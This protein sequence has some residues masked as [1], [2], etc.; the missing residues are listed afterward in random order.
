MPLYYK[1]SARRL[2]SMSGARISILVILLIT[3]A[4][5]FGACASSEPK[6]LPGY[7]VD[8][9]KY[10]H[11]N[12]DPEKF[13]G[14]SG[15]SKQGAA[16]AEEAARARLVRMLNSSISVETKRFMRTV[17]KNQDVS[18]E[19]GFIQKV[20]SRSEFRHDNLIQPVNI[21]VENNGT[22]W[23]FVCM[24]KER[25]AEALREDFIE[26]FSLFKTANTRA[27][28]TMNEQDNAA[29]TVA[30][31]QAAGYVP[32]LLTGIGALTSIGVEVREEEAQFR[33]AWV[34]L[35]AD[36]AS[37]RAAQIQLHWQSD[38]F[39]AMDSQKSMETF[40][41]ALGQL[42]FATGVGDDSCPK[43]E[44]PSFYVLS[45][46]ATN[47][48]EWGGLGFVC[49]PA[50][51]V[52]AHQCT[53]TNKRN[54]FESNISVSSAR[55]LDS[56]KEDKALSRALVNLTPEAITPLLRESFSSQ[57]PLLPFS[58]ADE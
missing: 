35:Q 26:Q 53:R 58:H 28:Q 55:G 19:S 12:C 6:S 33:P 47:G 9:R 56:R 1:T 40:Q 5:A 38:G 23:V 15:S 32:A 54:V 52:T 16:D 48:C 46:R 14:A 21:P 10:P 20:S 22:T 41:T 11:P 25:A 44:K 57:L 2:L 13:L 27:F 17:Q 45:V 18:F 34:A 3:L 7:F 29:F 50:F 51:H 43:T 31:R 39:S 4:L 24:S 36:A 42:G 30:Y 49:Q 8:W 37:I